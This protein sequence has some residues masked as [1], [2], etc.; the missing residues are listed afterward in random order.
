MGLDCSSHSK[1][2]AES[3]TSGKSRS[4]EENILSTASEQNTNPKETST[5]SSKVNS[6][7]SKAASIYF[8]KTA[9][10]WKRHVGDNNTT[11]NQMKFELKNSSCS[12]KDLEMKGSSEYVFPQKNSQH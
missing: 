7:Q 9:M 3:A 6:L 8:D 2:N 4:D 12:K 1:K 11:L 10:T 5:D